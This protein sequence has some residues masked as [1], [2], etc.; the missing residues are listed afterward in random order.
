[1]YKTFGK[2]KKPIMRIKKHGATK[3]RTAEKPTAHAA[4]ETEPMVAYLV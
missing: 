1:M 2:E 4:K 3:A